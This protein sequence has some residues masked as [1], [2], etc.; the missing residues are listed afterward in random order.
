MRGGK[1][2]RDRGELCESVGIGS[3]TSEAEPWHSH[4]DDTAEV[5]W[6]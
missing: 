4:E 1:E 5:E 2:A 3:T 6:C